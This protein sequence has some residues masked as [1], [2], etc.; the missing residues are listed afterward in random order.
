MTTLVSWIYL[1]NI[2]IFY[3]RGIH[4]SPFTPGMCKFVRHQAYEGSIEMK[5]ATDDSR[6]PPTECGGGNQCDDCGTGA[7]ISSKEVSEGEWKRID[8][9]FLSISAANISCR[10]T[11]SPRGM[12]PF[13]HLSDGHLDLILVRKASRLNHLRYLLRTGGDS[14]R[15]V[16][17]LSFVPFPTCST[18][19]SPSFDLSLIFLV[20]PAIRGALPRPRSHLHSPE[21]LRT[22][23][24]WN[25]GLC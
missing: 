7:P 21:V 6:R 4:V 19:P 17:C 25:L 20:L 2:T 9:R 8:G 14:R 10:C 23:H 11:L 22:N 18:P 16:S 5:L 15:A 12:A 13:A 3:F 24:N 1:G